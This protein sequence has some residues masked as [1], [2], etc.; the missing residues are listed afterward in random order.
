MSFSINSLVSQVA[1]T[2]KV[3]TINLT[4][5]LDSLSARLFQ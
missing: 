3:A 1:G 2:G 5:E 4:G